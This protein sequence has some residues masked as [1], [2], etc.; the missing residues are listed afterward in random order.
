MKIEGILRAI[1]V[2]TFYGDFLSGQDVSVRVK[3]G[4]LVG[5]GS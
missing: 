5:V 3:Q 1:V 2:I 4:T